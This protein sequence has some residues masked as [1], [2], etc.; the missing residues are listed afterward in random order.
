MLLY[1]LTNSVLCHP[2]M[3]T[4]SPAFAVCCCCYYYYYCYMIPMLTVVWWNLIVVLLCVFLNSREPEHFSCV[5]WPF[6]LLSF[7]KYLF[8]FFPHLLTGLFCGCWV[9][10]ILNRFWI[11]MLCQLGNLQISSPIPAVT[12]AHCISF[13]VCRLLS[14]T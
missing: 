11:S 4:S 3:H 12:S 7:E 9:L 5:Y 8:V 13:V 6:V 14:L 2:H 1:I 10:W